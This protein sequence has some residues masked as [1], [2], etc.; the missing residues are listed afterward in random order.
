MLLSTSPLS[1]TPYP[2][3]PPRGQRSSRWQGPEPEERSGRL[4]AAALPQGVT[5]ASLALW[6]A[7]GRGPGSGSGWGQCP[8][9]TCLWRGVTKPIPFSF[10]F[11]TANLPQLQRQASSH[12][13]HAPSSQ[14]GENSKV[15]KTL[16]QSLPHPHHHQHQQCRWL[17]TPWKVPLWASLCLCTSTCS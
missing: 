2:A 11:P 9:L 4:A 15:R 1:Q 10:S 12:A 7:R 6:E 16:I 14:E 13:T 5:A 8:G 17:P 3:L